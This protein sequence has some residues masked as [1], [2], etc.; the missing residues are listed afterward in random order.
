M[1]DAGRP[2]GYE[3]NTAKLLASEA[4]WKAADACLQTYGG[5]SQATEFD[6]GRVWAETRLFQIA[7]ISTNM[8]LAFIGHKVLGLPK[9]YSSSIAQA[10]RII[11]SAA[12]TSARARARG[13]WMPWF[14]PIGR[15]NTSR[16]LA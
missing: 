6:V 5:F 9:S 1:L 12:S 10:R 8:I 15:P 16:S 11:S 2:C 3:A 7:P 4:A 14:W 13:N